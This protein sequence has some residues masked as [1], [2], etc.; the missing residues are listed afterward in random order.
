MLTPAPAGAFVLPASRGQPLAPPLRRELESAFG[1]D[2]STVRLHCDAAAADAASILGARAFASGTHVYFGAGEFR[3]QRAGGRELLA[4]EIAHVLQQTGRVGSGGQIIASALTGCAP[5]QMMPS[6]ETMRRRHGGKK[7]SVEFG[8]IADALEALGDTR[9]DVEQFAK[10]RW[11]TI[12]T[13]PVEAESLLYDDLKRVEAFDVAAEMIE[14]DGFNGGKR[15]RS[16]EYSEKLVESLK[17]RSSGDYVFY[18]AIKREPRLQL[19]YG[20]MLRLVEMF[21]LQPTTRKTPP[22]LRNLDPEA[23]AASKSWQDIAA[24]LAEVWARYSDANAPGENEWFYNGLARLKSLNDSRITA[25]DNARSKVEERFPQSDVWRRRNLVA[26]VRSWAASTRTSYFEKDDGTGKKVRDEEETARWKPFF[27]DFADK[28]DAIVARI[29]SVWAAREAFELARIE[30][31]A[32]QA[33]DARARIAPEQAGVLKAVQREAVASGVAAALVAMM[34]ALNA[35]DKAGGRIPEDYAARSQKHADALRKLLRSKLDDSML[36]LFRKN[37]LERLEAMLWLEGRVEKIIDLLEWREPPFGAERKAGPQV[38]VVETSPDVVIG[39]RLAIAYRIHEL[40]SL[41][42]SDELLAAVREVAEAKKEKESVLSLLP[43]ESGKLWRQDD[44]S[45]DKIIKDFSDKA[46][47]GNEPLT[48]YEM[49]LMYRADYLEQLRARLEVALPGTAAEERKA[50]AR[51]PSSSILTTE[52]RGTRTQMEQAGQKPE[53]WFVPDKHVFFA[54]HAKGDEFGDVLLARAAS[55]PWY[56]KARANGMQFVRH[57]HFAG[58][59]FI[60]AFPPYARSVEVLRGIAALNEL[61]ASKLFGASDAKAIEQLRK[62]ENAKWLTTV[63]DILQV[64]LDPKSDARFSEVELRS[65]DSRV[66]TAIEAHYQ[67]EKA[68]LDPLV[69][70]AARIDRRVL[71][72]KF[73]GRLMA[74]K[75]EHMIL[76]DKACL[77]VAEDINR[78]YLQLLAVFETDIKYE[79]ELTSGAR[80][81]RIMPDAKARL[82]LAALMLELA[83]A[84]AA[85]FQHSTTGNVVLAWLGLLEDAAE[86]IDLLWANKQGERAI[87]LSE[88]QRSDA[89]VSA[90]QVIF[91]SVLKRLQE[92]QRSV[93]MES[94]FSADDASSTLSVRMAYSSPI[95]P[96]EVLLPRTGQGFM[97]A[98]TTG[99]RYRLIKVLRSFVYH[100][101]FG[102]VESGRRLGY[103]KPILKEADNTTDLK[104]GGALLRIDELD[105]NDDT[106]RSI[107]VG[108]ATAEDFKLLAELYSGAAYLAFGKSMENI[109]KGIEKAVDT[110]LDLAE[111]IPGWGQLITGARVVV[112]ISEF[113]AS[114]AYDDLRKV[115]NGNLHE[116][117]A[118]LYD[119]LKEA[120]EPGFL[121]EQLMFPDPTIE[122]I[123]SKATDFGTAK[124]DKLAAK[125]DV[126]TRGKFAAVRKTFEAIKKLGR[127]FSRALKTLNVKVQRPVEDFQEYVSV[128]PALA[129]AVHFAASHLYELEALAHEAVVLALTHDDDAAAAAKEGV[130]LKD[131]LRRLLGVEQKDI[132]RRVHAIMFTLEHLELPERLIDITP[133]VQ[134]VLDEMISFVG[135]KLG[136]EAKFVI[137]ILRRSG[138]MDYFTE[139]IARELVESGF[140][141]NVYWRED[142]LPLVSDKFNALRTSTVDA[143]NKV[144]KQPAFGGLFDE[145]PKGDVI[146]LEPNTES[147]YPELLTGTPPAPAPADDRVPAVSPAAVPAFGAGSKLTR[148]LRQ[149]YET[150]FGHDFSHVRLHAGSEGEAMTRAYGVDALTSGSH[151]F[152]RH[153]LDPRGGRG[154]GVMRHELAHVLQQGGARPVGARQSPRPVRG[155]TQAGLRFMPESEAEAERIASDVRNRRSGSPVAIGSRA[156]AGWQPFAFDNLSP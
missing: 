95:G 12:G 49:L 52:S 64:K 68:K 50:I 133:A 129:F 21:L 140:D 3:A 73:A 101:P 123:L 20:E 53:R 34:N 94:G 35:S 110:M 104:P 26:Y 63:R 144:L 156:A 57:E 13:W 141:P 67:A 149:R 89:W 66:E 31:R 134:F 62:V 103:G 102:G 86:S 47:K 119:K 151:V 59:A 36:Y 130:D 58:R 79:T 2:L 43:D 5:V 155:Q 8:K 146:T 113:W 150:E 15:I 25:C 115:V 148:G 22:L 112:A 56:A 1:A 87:Y 45:S 106:I 61:V 29:D 10:N 137:I 83:G 44:V 109:Q 128:R 131:G 48:P 51:A 124:S 127:A 32:A 121:I 24:H 4:H 147:T 70:H 143:L 138:A 92:F 69:Q 84:A 9:K 132:G 41:L 23:G 118:G 100:P 18:R 136:L 30:Y 46:I 125:R 142:V 90:N 81:L 107:D 139:K 74:V 145:I 40:A 11:T 55:E 114:G 82:H 154:E 99:K 80:A 91:R 98:D 88:E 135:G 37:Q 42:G 78:L 153:G 19:Y 7:P 96:G 39:H 120:A 72:A 97:G 60:W 65:F 108:F 126:A 85:V 122:A 105:A 28:L 76:R 6:F 117:M 93:Q 111:L 33:K 152:L 54:K 16:T 17:K 14:R 27:D 38:Q 71:T 77:A 116:I 75:D